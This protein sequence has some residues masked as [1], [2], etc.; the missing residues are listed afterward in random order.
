MATYQQIKRYVKQT[1]GYTVSSCSIAHVKEICGLE[2][3]KAWNRK[4]PRANPCPPDKI[5]PITQAF[6]RFGM[7]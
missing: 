3:R 2:L 4:Y 5:E 7:I 1:Y 6:R